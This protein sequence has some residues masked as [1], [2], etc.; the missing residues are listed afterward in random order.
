[1]TA[2]GRQHDFVSRYFWPA[3]GGDE[4]PVTGSIHAGLAPY[5]AER[6]GRTSLVALQA[7]RR[8]GELYCRVE[9]ARVRVSGH[10]VQYL[11][12]TIEI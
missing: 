12:G 5:W 3:N 6:L 8:S 11:H 1:M 10:A 9:G 2:P 4:D 7:S